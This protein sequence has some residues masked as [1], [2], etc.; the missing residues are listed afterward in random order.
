MSQ[1]RRDFLRNAGVASA[2]ALAGNRETAGA[3]NLPQAPNNVQVVQTSVLDIGYEEHGPGDGFPIVLL[4]GFPY[5][6]RSFDGAVGPLAEAG[7]RVLVPYLRGYG[8][9]RFRDPD[10]PR[11]AEQAVIAEALARCSFGF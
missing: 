6:V 9:T 10:A 2:A 8:P 5:D 7:H 11:M 3:E 4:H 1:S